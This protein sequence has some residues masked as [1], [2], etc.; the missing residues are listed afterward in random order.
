M[1]DVIGLQK[2]LSEKQLLDA[3]YTYGVCDEFTMKAV[4]LYKKQ[5]NLANT[6]NCYGKVGK[7]TW[8]HMGLKIDN[9]YE[10]S[11]SSVGSNGVSSDGLFAS[12]LVPI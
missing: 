11:H 12:L 8:E 4:N 10:I 5:H 6:G 9:D 7:T 3:R 2:V 1:R